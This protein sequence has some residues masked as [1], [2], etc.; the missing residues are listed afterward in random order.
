[1]TN[2][3]FKRAARQ[4]QIAYREKY[5]SLENNRYA[6]WLS[7]ADGQKGRNFYV[8]LGVFE[9][10]RQRYPQFYVD[11]YSDML[12]SEHIPFNLFVPFLQNL[13]FCKNVFNERMSGCIKSIENIK[14][15]YAPSPKEN[16]LDDGTSFDAYIEYT[17]ADNSKGMI[18][19][20]VKYTEKE[21]PLDPNSKQAKDINDKKGKYYAISEMSGLYKPNSIETL[22][23]DLFRQIW[24]N[25]LLAESIRLVDND[26]FKHATSMLFYPKDNGHFAETNKKYCEMLADN[27]KKF[28]SITYEDFFESCEKHCPNNDFKKWIDYLSE[29]Y[30]INHIN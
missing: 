23:T 25:H 8:G 29:R 15:E 5:I 12:R 11:L 30:I 14:I 1:M 17:H 28:I 7:D 3:E 21:Y 16:Y 10:V 2:S 27:D 24:R 9:S 4:H 19:I 20:E 18:G 13:E 22:K 6:T 26:K